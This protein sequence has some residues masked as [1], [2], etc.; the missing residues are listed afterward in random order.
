MAEGTP[1]HIIR[2]LDHALVLCAG[3]TGTLSSLLAKV[4]EAQHG[5]PIYE[6]V[7][8][9]GISHLCLVLAMHI[10][11]ADHPRALLGETRKHTALIAQ[12]S[13]M[14]GM[15]NLFYFKSIT[16]IP[17][18]DTVSLVSSVPLFAGILA[19]LIFAEELR[20]SDTL[21]CVGAVLGVALIMGPSIGSPVTSDRVVGSACALASALFMA[22]AYVFVR[23]MSTTTT[24]GA[25]MPLSTVLAS[26]A[27]GV[28]VM[29]PVGAFATRSPFFAQTSE[30]A[31]APE[32]WGL[33]LTMAA[34]GTIM[35]A[36]LSIALRRMRAV[37]GTVEMMGAEVTSA[38]VLQ[39]LFTRR[40]DALPTLTTL[41]GVI[42]IFGSSVYGLLLPRQLE[43]DHAKLIDT[44]TGSDVQAGRKTRCGASL[45]I[46]RRWWTRR[47]ASEGND[48]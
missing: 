25:Q 1:I 30:P 26:N 21:A 34:C 23:A 18:A 7:F 36:S 38:L 13:F 37:M 41:A 17:L 45:C 32:A 31:R 43:T 9:R 5:V 40:T 42:V 28:L 8:M 2:L 19:R 11:S 27:W 35:Q 24:S 39:S 3:L 46:T 15:G 6:V 4:L 20:V 12:R 22:L 10:W 14:S 29:A 47:T 33:L 16:L 48:E 44:E